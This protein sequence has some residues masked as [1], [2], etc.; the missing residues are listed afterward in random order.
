MRTTS[1]FGRLRLSIAE[2][3]VSVPVPYVAMPYRDRDVQSE[4]PPVPRNWA[5]D[6]ACA[7]VSKK[8]D[9]PN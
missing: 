1:R 8:S 6:F 4:W 3:E 2:A 5:H 7:L 9:L